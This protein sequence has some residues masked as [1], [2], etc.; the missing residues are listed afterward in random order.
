M[1]TGTGQEPSRTL[2]KQEA[3]RHLIHTAIRLIEKREDPFAIHVFVHSADKLLI[4]MAKQQ[5][6]ELHFD[7]EIYVKPE[8]H[9][10]FFTKHR[11]IYN[12]FKHADKDF[13]DDLPIIRDIMKLNVF[14]LAICAANY[15]KMFGEITSHMVLLP[16]LVMALFPEMIKP[17]AVEGATLLDGISSFEGMTAGELF[18]TFENNMSVLPNYVGE[19]L[20]DLEDI[21][22][23]YLLTFVELRAGKTKRD[24]T[25]HIR[26]Y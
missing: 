26:E 5:G 1:T 21:K 17:A 14:T 13:D 4:D 12:Y 3:I 19:L 25:L 6:Q 18:E 23:F 24:R 10:Q 11:A 7:W 2:D 20:K 9:K 8:Y 15:N 16:V 22:E